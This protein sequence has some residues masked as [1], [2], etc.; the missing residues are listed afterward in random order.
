MRYRPLGDSG[1]LVSVQGLGC[2]NF[3]SRLDVDGARAVVDAAIDAGVTLFDTSDTYG[4]GGGS[5]RALGEILGRRR[6][7][8]VLATKFG[9][10]N[11]DLGYGPAAGAKGGRAYIRRAVTES[12]RR[13][14][15]DYIDL[16]QL[17]TPD[18]VTPVAE[19]LAALD[20]LV[21]EGKV[22]YLGHSNFA[23]WQ[24]ADAAHLAARAGRTP[25]ISAQNHWS[26]LEREAEAEVVPAARHFGLGV[27]PYFPLAN[28]LLTGKIRKGQP[29]PQDSRLA[30][31]TAYVTEAK[32]ARVEALIAWGQEHGVTILQAAI[33]ALAA[34]PGCASVIAGAMN[35]EQVKANVAA[36][37]WIPS[38]AELAQIDQIVPPPPSR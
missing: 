30:G 9:H 2:N 15:T 3:G 6:D 1:L 36:S 23:G 12:L 28:G 17:H 31:R 35:P 22:R 8:V 4:G 14:R 27:L 32:L 26:L 20:E 34:Q 38:A 7:Q 11:A 29:V 16:Y 10:Q 18:P 33:G 5:E 25:F 19:T 13:L 37:E 21:A 24:V